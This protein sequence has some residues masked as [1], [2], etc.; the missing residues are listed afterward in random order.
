MQFT[1]LLLAI[2]PFIGVSQAILC[3]CDRSTTASITCCPDIQKWNGYECEPADRQAYTDCCA[4]QF[5][6]TTFCRDGSV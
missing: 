2:V 3:S 5:S 4:D 6:T 1:Q